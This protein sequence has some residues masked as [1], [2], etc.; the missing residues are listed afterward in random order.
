MTTKIILFIQSTA[1]SAVTQMQRLIFRDLGVEDSKTISRVTTLNVCE[2][3]D[4][5]EVL[6][7][8]IHS[9]RY[10]DLSSRTLCT[11]QPYFESPNIRTNSSHHI[12][13]WKMADQEF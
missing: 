9:N 4:T 12:H 3:G 10:L 2:T 13:Q 8:V 6:W 7:N 11:Q 1:F 5:P